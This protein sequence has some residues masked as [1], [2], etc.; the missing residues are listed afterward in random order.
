MTSTQIRI[1]QAKPSDMDFII[2][3]LPRLSE[4]G[5]PAWRSKS[6]MLSVDTEVLK[7]HLINLSDESS[8]FIAEDALAIPLGFIHLHEGVDYYYKEK[9]GHIADLIVAK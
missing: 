2:S 9:H 3:I 1:R 4:F 7:N 6:E 8:I 5:P